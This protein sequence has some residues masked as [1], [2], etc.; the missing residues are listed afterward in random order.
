MSQQGQTIAQKGIYRP[1]SLKLTLRGGRLPQRAHFDLNKL[2]LTL[3]VPLIA[4][5][6]YLLK[7]LA[8]FFI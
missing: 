7:P 3:L 1:V 6:G 8:R 4:Y 5:Q 2:T